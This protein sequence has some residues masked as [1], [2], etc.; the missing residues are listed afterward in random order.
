MIIVKEVVKYKK[1]KQ[2]I[3]VL[4]LIIIPIKFD[5]ANTE[6][7]KELESIVGFQ[8]SV[9]DGDDYNNL[10]YPDIKSS[11]YKP[12]LDDDETIY[13]YKNNNHV[14]LIN[15]KQVAGFFN[16][17]YFCHKCKKTYKDVRKRAESASFV[18]GNTLRVC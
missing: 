12:P 14:D 2:E 1:Q 9:I 17:D 6:K 3:Y 13:L 18:I 11:D 8:I 16:K 10:F 15:N 4:I 7:I 5:L